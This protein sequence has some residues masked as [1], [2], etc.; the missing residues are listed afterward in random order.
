VSWYS[1]RVEVTAQREEAMAALFAAGAQGV[2]EDG[3]QLVTHFEAEYAA[4]AAAEA[5]AAAAPGSTCQ[6][7]PSTPVDWS[8]AWRNHAR[9][10]QLDRQTIAPPW[11]AECIDPARLIVCD[12][13][14]AFGT[15]DLAST[16]GAARL[17]VKVV[18]PGHVVADLG[19]GSAVLSIVAARLGASRA[20]AIES[21][22]D[23]QE[24]AAEN[25]ARNDV[26]PVVHM[27]EGDAEVMLPLVAPVDIIVANIISS[28]IR[29]ML[30]AMATALRPHGVAILAGI[31]AA[32][33]DEMAAELDRCGWSIQAEDRE[34]EWWSTLV[35][36]A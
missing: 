17:L 1:L 32:E 2:H 3:P 36:R 22:P 31:L 34:D 20:W 23:A 5:V 33:R 28:V 19:S 27:L 14:M 4:R 35:A 25:V 21:D 13:G 24:S 6:V 30:P 12:P 29:S 11:L 15:G 7:A 10:F 16:R 9:V 8:T 18:R 26:G